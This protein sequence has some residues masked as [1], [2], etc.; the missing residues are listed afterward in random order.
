V[1]LVPRRRLRR[2]R[3]RRLLR[4]RRRRQQ[5]GQATPLSKWR[6]LPWP[7][8]SPGGG[9]PAGRRAEGEVRGAAARAAGHAPFL[10]RSGPAPPRPA[11]CARAGS[12]APWRCRVCVGCQGGLQAV[13]SPDDR[14]GTPG[15]LSCAVNV[16]VHRRFFGGLPENICS[17]P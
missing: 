16:F 2:R 5:Q 4:Q 13:Q 17:A 15:A 11:P 12:S 10:P 3:R 7:V 6:R 9:A 14:A 8:T 1:L